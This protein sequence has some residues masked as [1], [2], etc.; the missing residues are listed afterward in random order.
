MSTVTCTTCAHASSLTKHGFVRCKVS[1]RPGWT[2]SPTWP[3]TCEQHRLAA[4]AV[5]AKRQE[6]LNAR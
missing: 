3:R 5:I 2:P 1:R 4:P 6:A